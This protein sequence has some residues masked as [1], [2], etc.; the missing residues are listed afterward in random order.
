[1]PRIGAEERAHR[2]QRFIDAAWRC[3][4]RMGYR[5]MTVDDVCIELGASK[6]A[7][8]GY[9][10]SKHALLLA[11]LNDDAA[12]IDHFMSTLEQRSV[13]PV[14]RLRRFA[15]TML[16]RGSDQSRVQVRADLWAAAITEPEV[17]DGLAEMVRHR[18]GCLRS[19]VQQAVDAGDLDLGDVPSNALASLLL[20]LA[21]GL[22][23]HHAID[24]SS[25][26]WNNVARVLDEVFAALAPA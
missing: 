5:D 26:R 20:A 4:S 10:A 8:Y 15:K 25:F 14:E 19:W 3:A 11:L 13:A 18:R 7:F 9:F 16:E 2:R 17:R 1:M 23:L 22:M 12:E 21:D 24:P 6:G